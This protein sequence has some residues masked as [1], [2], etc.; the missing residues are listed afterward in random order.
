[1]RFANPAGLW[2]ALLV[3]PIIVLHVLKPRRQRV[4]VSSVF[5]W[6]E[7]PRPVSAAVP[8]HRLRPSW[9][10]LAQILAALLLAGLVANPIRS[11]DAIL[12]DHTVFIIDASGSMAARDGD[13]DRLAD[14]VAIARDLREQ[15]PD[16]AIASVVEAGPRSRVLLSAS[17]DDV[18]FERA[19]D[20]IEVS[21]A[22]SDFADAFLLAESLETPGVPIGFALISDGGLTLAEQ[23]LLPL[24]T[25]YHQ[26]GSSS[27]NRAASGLVVEPS[28]S[29]LRVIATV[30]NHGSQRVSQPVRLDVDGLT[31]ADTVLDIAAN[32]V[33]TW[34]LETTAGD[35]V[36]LFLESEDLLDAD[37]HA[38]AVAARRRELT[39]ALVGPPDPFLERALAVIPSLTLESGTVVDPTLEPDLIVYNG[40]D[41]PADPSAPFIAIAPPGGAPGITVTGEVGGPAVTLVD[42][43]NGLLSNL[44]LSDV[45]IAGAQ[46]V[47]AVEGRVLVAAPGAPLLIE[48][49]TGRRPFLYL[50]F[51]LADTNLPLQVAFPIL[52]DRMV[53][54][55]AGGSLP[56]TGLEVG[57]QIP[58][59]PTEVVTVIAPAGQELTVPPGTPSPRVDRTGFWRVVDESGDE[60]TIA[61][62]S[63]ASESDVDPVLGLPTEL[64]VIEPG[65]ERPRG[66]ESVREW[67]LWPLL[68][69]VAAEFLLA[70]R[71]VGVTTRQWRVA[72]GARVAVVGLLVAALVGVTVRRSAGEVATVFLIDGSDSV[73]TGGRADSVDWVQDALAAQPDGARSAI[74]L[75]GADARLELTLQNDNVLGVPAVQIDG[76]ETDAERALRLAG[77]VLPTDARRRIVLLSDGRF[78]VG[79]DEL[80]AAVLGQNGV[81]I[82]VVPVGRA[83]GL[84]VAVADV[85]S[86]GT[87]RVGER[88]AIE[89]TI[90][91]S[92]PATVLVSLLVGAETVE[93]RAL[94]VDAGLTTVRFEREA[95]EAELARY[96]VRV[97][98]AGD[99][100]VQ[101]DA[102]FGAIRVEGP[103][104]VLL[105]EGSSGEG[106]VLADALEAGGLTVVTTSPAVIPP[107]DELST[108]SAVVLVDVDERDL[109]DAQVE[110]ISQATRDLGRGLVVLGGDRSYGLGGYLDSELEELLPVV[111]EILDP[112]RRQTVAEVLAIDTSGSMGNCHCNEEAAPGIGG[113][114]ND[115][116][117]NKTDIS[118]AGA[119]RAIEALSENDEVGVLAFNSREQWIIDLQKLPSEDVVNAGL[120]G[121]FPSGGTDVQ[122]SL[123]T[124]AAALRES[125]AS[126]KH[127]IFFSDGFTNLDHLATLAEEAGALAAEG[128]TVSVIATGEGAAS[129]LEAIAIEGHGRFYPGR[130][131]QQIPELIMEEAVIA[132]RDFI[133]EGEFFPEITSSSE[134]ID[135]L[136]SS[137]AL[138]GYVG[139]TE[140]PTARTLL[141]IGPD[142][143]PLLTTWQIG[144]G[145]ATAWSS[146]SGQRWGQLWADWDGFVDFWTRTVKDTFP[147]GDGAGAL[148]ARVSEDRIE[149]E[150]EGAETFPDGAT[151]IARITDPDGATVEVP[152][153][154]TGGS[155][156]EA[157]VAID[158]TGTFAVGAAVQASGEALLSVSTLASSSFA[159]EYLPGD[160][161]PETLLRLSDLSGGRGA[162]EPS[163]AFDT[164]DLAAGISE[165]DLGPLLLL[166]AALLWPIA[167]ALSRLSLRTAAVTN[168]VQTA[169]RGLLDRFPSLPGRPDPT[170]RPSSTPQRPPEPAAPPSTVDQ[171]LRKKRGEP[172]RDREA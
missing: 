43:N 26:V 25:T 88:Y 49:T 170:R 102:A 96:Q 156:F 110:L 61:V 135:N 130:D 138:L 73:T 8:W 111:S 2:L 24:D 29:G 81:Q 148:T 161:E 98:A 99:A 56:P 94:E 107:L 12:A 79:D 120:G 162:I 158:Q 113:P 10:L 39:V 27:T 171:L 160:P 119:A 136:S 16:G 91:A 108:Y 101:N 115:G 67:L 112:E 33:A 53:G 125:K 78:T 87:V 132:S 165:V 55:L 153:Q 166:L 74:A 28:G 44:D 109:T 22:G 23:R 150:L 164:A 123:S 137:P 117:A 70:R 14:A 106:E 1:M 169:G 172:D 3:I 92:E 154:R 155:R 134:V 122:S 152:L 42:T 68:A 21:A 38:Y 34:E 143:D 163:Q 46:Q 95:T 124:A 36:D 77:A 66:E 104:T 57:N 142:R 118:R 48:S 126:L 149:L 60:T 131:L 167:L 141:R 64:R 103:P 85:S 159:A 19:L 58:L 145:Q 32:E 146:D 121:L 97:S 17:P 129:E 72:V 140:K 157:E 116:G 139:T 9:L 13:P 63:P 89:A 147:A 86:L 35:R 20:S 37:D 51:S 144:I 69:V 5:L 6:D 133:T 128:I 11:T 54:Q 82:D 127:I 80:E 4:P 71:R 75:F 168:R 18:A 41:P 47:E 31:V 7:A 151:A 45:V 50:S 105:V 40:V 83:A 84:D 100:I 93:E 114:R 30:T 15:M 59:S 90:A 52:V 76:S 65:E 62:N